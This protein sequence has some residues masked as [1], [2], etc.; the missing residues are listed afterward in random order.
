MKPLSP[1]SPLHN[2]PDTIFVRRREP[3]PPRRFADINDDSEPESYQPSSSGEETRPKRKERRE[4][5]GTGYALKPPCGSC[6]K[7]PRLCLEEIGGG[8]CV[9]CFRL[10]YKCE[11]A[12]TKGAAAV[13][14]PQRRKIT[15]EELQTSRTKIEDEGVKEKKS[16]S[17]KGKAKAKDE[18]DEESV[19]EERAAGPMPKY[20]H[21]SNDPK[22]KRR[23]A[24]RKPKPVEA[25]PAPAPAQMDISHLVTKG[26]FV[27]SNSFA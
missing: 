13:P 10:K 9:G 12:K 14:A 21:V 7:I 16:R 26:S 1:T 11:Y 22:P 18:E 25:A 24:Q 8:A 27:S 23:R 17:R 4:A 6:A 5:V 20:V 2:D 3:T 19:E 15:L